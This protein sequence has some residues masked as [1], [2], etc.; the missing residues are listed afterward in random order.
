[1]NAGKLRERL[2]FQIPAGETNENGFPI[3][4]PTHYKTVWGG[5]KT[6]RGNRFYAAAQ[7]NM[8]NNRE[9]TIRY[10][11]SLDENER[12]NNLTVVWNKKEHEIVSIENDDGLNVSMTVVVRSLA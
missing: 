3:T 1:M 12:P 4:E 10:Q 9:F 7:N 5:L 11:K 2:K 8:E 6:L